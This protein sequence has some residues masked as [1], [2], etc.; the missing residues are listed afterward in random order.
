MMKQ[1]PEAKV[2]LTHRPFDR[3]Y[4]S[5]S[6]TVRKA[7]PQTLSEKLGMISK[8]VLDGDLRK[9][10]RAIK[11]F[12][13]IFWEGQ[14]NGEFENKAEAERIF[15]RHIEEVKEYVPEEKLLVYEVRQ[16]WGPLCAFLGV[17]VPDQEF[18]HLNKKENFK[19]MIGHLIKGEMA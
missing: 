10:I 1:Y 9:R 14:F 13:G 6:T 2:I 5:A 11:F 8:M 7:G 17:D 4:E 3:W 12:E 18:P 19:E 16:G 15:T